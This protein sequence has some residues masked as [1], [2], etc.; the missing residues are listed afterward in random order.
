MQEETVQA[1]I[2]RQKEGYESIELVGWAQ[3][4]SYDKAEHKL[5]WARDL[6]VGKADGHTLNYAIRVLG[7]TGVLQVNIVGDIKQLPEINPKV[8]AL[9]GMVSF[10]EG[11]RYAD[12]NED[13]DQVAAYGLAG[14]IAGGVAAKAGLFKGF[15][16]LLLASKKLLIVG[17][18]AFGGA[19]WG[20]IKWLFGRK[21]PS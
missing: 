18:I 21:T 7:R 3:T 14:L 19:I 1:N 15:I 6:K 20:G 17:A 5:Y 12:F 10:N 9:L 13:T 16:A 11:Q 2:E 8:P 4:P